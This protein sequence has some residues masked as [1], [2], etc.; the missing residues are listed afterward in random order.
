MG[1]L[2]NS[3]LTA[4]KIGQSRRRVV[5]TPDYFK[6]KGVPRTPADLAAHQAVVYEQPEGGTACGN[7]ATASTSNNAPG[8]ASCGT[9]MVVLAG[10]AA[11]FTYF[12]RTSR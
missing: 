9:P 3:A 4:R 2:A 10:G 6:A 7:T 1:E 8:R 12:S 11:V 5:G